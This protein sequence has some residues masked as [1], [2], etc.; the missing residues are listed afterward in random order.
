MCGRSAPLYQGYYPVCDPDDP[1]HSCC[2]PFGYGSAVIDDWLIFSI[3][4]ILKVLWFGPSV[5]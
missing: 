5:L 2:G 4:N 3:D 1:A